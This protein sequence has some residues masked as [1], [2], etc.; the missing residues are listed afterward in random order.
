VC[1]AAVLAIAVTAI[2][3]C[4]GDEPLVA[5]L[6]NV[7][8]VATA[9]TPKAHSSRELARPEAK[10]LLAKR[11]DFPRTAATDTFGIGD[12]V[13]CENPP[14]LVGN[15]QAYVQRGLVTLTAGPESNGDNRCRDAHGYHFDVE[16][17]TWGK[18]YMVGQ[19]AGLVDVQTCVESLG[20]VTGV[21]SEPGGTSATVEYTLVQR[22]TPYG[23][24]R[25]TGSRTESANFRLYDDGWRIVQ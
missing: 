13:W 6:G 23:D 24:G 25:C 9:A 15:L 17:T 18:L 3:G 14:S 22:Q 10:R 8:S 1:A 19:N 5:Q 2:F 16:L 7:T 20:D 11:T 12:R 21:S 4:N